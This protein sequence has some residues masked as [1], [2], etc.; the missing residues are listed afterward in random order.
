MTTLFC[1]WVRCAYRLNRIGTAIAI[2]LPPTLAGGA[3]T[4][5]AR[6]TMATA[7]ASSAELPEDRARLAER[8]PPDLSMVKATDTEPG[9]APGG[10]RL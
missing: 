8:T 10:K 1:F 3:G 5:L 7:S 6:R 9:E 4:G 2:E